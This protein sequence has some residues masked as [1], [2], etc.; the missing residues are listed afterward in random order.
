MP[1]KITLSVAGRRVEAFT[2]YHID[3]DLYTAGDAFSLTMS[4]PGVVINDGARCQLSVNDRLEMT[5]IVDRVTEANSK[6]GSTVTVEGRDLM[7][8]VVDSYVEQFVTLENIT[9]KALAEQLLATVPFINRKAIEYQ[10]GIAG[11]AA[12]KTGSNS[13]LDTAQNKAQV[14]PG[15]TIFEVLKDYA[16]SR[17][18]MFFS[19]PNGTFV[20]GRPKAKGKPVFKLTRRRDGRGNN[21]IEGRRIRDI[22]QRYSKIIVLGQQQGSDPL[23]AEEINTKAEILDDQ[24][25]FYKPFV[26]VNNNDGKSPAE[27]ARLLLERQRAMGLQLIYKVRGHSQG[28]RNWTINELCEIEDEKFGIFGTFLIYGR[29]LNLDKKDGPI[30]EVR[31][32]LPGVIK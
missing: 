1:D 7:G 20:F 5:G 15:Q 9:L 26:T 11:A 31:L 32:G 19:L 6:Q 10:A 23:G 30:T 21:V 2:D 12:A 14:E 28:S 29:A 8:L 27:H 17:G 3:S 22:S 24:V 16:M 4:D 18:A 13:L 25:P